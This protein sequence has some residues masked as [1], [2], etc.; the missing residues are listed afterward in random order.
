MSPSDTGASSAS[1]SKRGSQGTK[2]SD[3]TNPAGVA[4]GESD[5][6]PTGPT[7]GVDVVEPSPADQP[8]VQETA[9]SNGSAGSKEGLTKQSPKKAQPDPWATDN[10]SEPVTRETV[11]VDAAATNAYS[12]APVYGPVPAGAPNGPVPGP[13]PNGPSA[14][15]PNPGRPSPN[16]PVATAYLAGASTGPPPV[17]G[18]AGAAVPASSAARTSMAR[19]ARL[20]VSHL[21]PLSVLRI[22]LTFS[23][24]MFIVLLV[25]VAALW[26]VLDSAGVFRSIINAAT[27]LTNDTKDNHPGVADWLSFSR[28]MLIALVLG[29]ANVIAFTLLSTI[30]AMLYNLCSDFVGGVEVTL[31]ER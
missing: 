20:K 17:P 12:V 25:A 4:V 28:V 26:A 27:T 15:G 7:K 2:A 11:N 18:S 10:G 3:D 1:Q 14:N 22:S 6:A 16:G 9:E 23:L 30:G 21:G 5:D 24:C 19:R 31:I 29:A 13:N 8:K